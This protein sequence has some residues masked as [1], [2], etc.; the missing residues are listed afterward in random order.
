ME[1]PGFALKHVDVRGA[2]AT[3]REDVVR[4]AAFGSRPNMWLIDLGGARAR[5]EALPYVKS[6]TLM[7]IPPATVA[8]AIIER[9]PAGCLIGVGDAEGLVD[10]EGRVLADACPSE[11]TPTYRAPVIV[12]APGGFIHDA[13]LS[14]LFADSAALRGSGSTF[15]ALSHDRFGQFEATLVNG[16]VVRFGDETQ[17]A[18]KSRLVGPIL[19]TAAQQLGPVESIDLRAAGTPVVRYRGGGTVPVVPKPW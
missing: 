9:T 6:A 1:W 13:S 19:T 11:T 5:I 12:P 15:V 4:R 14:Q 10:G 7:R 17:L 8:I 3:S 16:V 2:V 18:A